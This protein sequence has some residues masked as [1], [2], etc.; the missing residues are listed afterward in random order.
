M[1]RQ[2]PVPLSDSVIV[3]EMRYDM[4]KYSFCKKTVKEITAKITNNTASGR[5]ISS[6]RK[7]H[8]DKQILVIIT[9]DINSQMLNELAKFR[10]YGIKVN[11]LLSKDVTSIINKDALCKKI[12]A[13]NLYYE[14]KICAVDK[15][16][17][18]VSLVI[19]AVSN[20]TFVSKLSQGIQDDLVSKVIY[21]TLASNKSV[22]MD[23]ADIK[24]REI[25][26]NIELNKILDEQLSTAKKMGIKEIE[27]SEYLMK[28]LKFYKVSANI[29]FDATRNK[30]LTSKR[31]YAREVITKSDISKVEDDIKILNISAGTIVTALARDIASRRGIKI[32]KK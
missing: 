13:T 26:K 23:A 14:G 15:M 27:I 9:A 10:R 11:L 1:T 7:T 16:L 18:G 25:T 8:A 4:D 22:Y 29:K 5:K 19:I 32:I 12:G 30:D 28:T 20:L 17:V 21:K 2:V 31:N 24:N 3:V 6:A